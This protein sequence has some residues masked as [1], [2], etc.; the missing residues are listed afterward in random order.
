[1]FSR[2]LRHVP[3][4]LHLARN[5]TRSYS[6]GAKPTPLQWTA[7]ALLFG[8]GV[9][10]GGYFAGRKQPEEGRKGALGLQHLSAS[11]TPL[12]SLE[13]PK[14]ANDEDFDTALHQITKIVGKENVTYDKAVLVA[15]NDTPFNTHHPPDPEHQ[16]PSIVVF[17]SSTQEVSEIMKVA[18]KYRVPVVANSGL[19]SLEGHNMHT[20]GP[21]SISLAFGNLNEVLEFHPDDLDAVV[22]PGVG[23]Q[24]LDDY[25]LDREDGKH[26]MF[27]PDP[28][29]GAAIAGMVG[30]SASGTNAYRY[31]TMKENVVNLTVVLADGTVVKTRQRPKKSS[32]GYDLT[33]IFIGS[34]GTLGIITEITVKL[35]PRPKQELVCIASFPTIKDAASTAQSIINKSGFQVN[36]LELLDETTTTFVNASGNSEKQFLERPTLLIKVGGVSENTVKEQIEVV[37][38]ISKQNNLIKFEQ[39]SNKEENNILW[40]ARRQGLWS[41]LD[42][43]SKVLANPNDVNVWTTDVAVPVSKLA[44]V[45]DETNEDLKNSIFNG[46]FAVMGHVG[47]GNCHFLIL[48]NTPDYMEAKKYVDRMVERAIKYEG[49]CTGEH[50]VGV[51]KRAYLESEVGK[52][53]V[54]LMRHL[55]FSLDP[56]AILNPDKVIQIDPHDKLDEHLNSGHVHEVQKCC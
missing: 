30:T 7:A 48:Y 5:S 39:S 1:M 35:Q 31:G 23:W 44:Q 34:E 6:S 47:D 55:K 14:Y 36:A 46:K 26:L 54:D 38:Q 37:E 12:D 11:T 28:G 3:K 41:T 17:P 24:D 29:M 33:H 53:A 22:Q 15:H 42:Y 10:A 20:R 2:T 27:G 25:L 45:V 56:K 13:T 18:H 19:T 32:A 50:G 43:G 52:N 9:A 8:S 16:R 40:T 21:N 51:G 4:R 49:T